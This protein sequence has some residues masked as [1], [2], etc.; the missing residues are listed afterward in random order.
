MFD[1]RLITHFDWPLLLLVMLTALIGIAN[2]YSATSSGS[3]LAFPVY[4][5]QIYWL[6][7]GILLAAI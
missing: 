4:L 7:G 1:R 2:L 3:T 6:G 5:K